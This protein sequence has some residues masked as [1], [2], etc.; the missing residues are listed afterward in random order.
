MGEWGPVISALLA[1]ILALLSLQWKDQRNFAKQ[2]SEEVK[3]KKDKVECKEDRDDCP[4]VTI[5][6]SS[7]SKSS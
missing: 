5:W 6:R 4:C 7:C 2:I 3:A 1:L